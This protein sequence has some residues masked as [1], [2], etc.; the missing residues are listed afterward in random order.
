MKISNPNKA[1][2]LENTLNQRPQIYKQG[3]WQQ[4]LM[5]HKAAHQTYNSFKN[6]Q[7]PHILVQSESLIT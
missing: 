1:E 2:V 7:H 4:N 3:S 5:N 6:L